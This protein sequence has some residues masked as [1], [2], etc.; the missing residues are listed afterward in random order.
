MLGGVPGTKS[1]LSLAMNPIGREV[2]QAIASSPYFSKLSMLDVRECGIEEEGALF[3]ALSPSMAALTSLDVWGNKLG[4]R[5]LSALISSPYLKRL[6]SLSLGSGVLRLLP[7]AFWAETIC[8]LDLRWSG[9]CDDDI[10]L[11]ANIGP[12]PV[13]ARLNLEGNPLTIEGVMALLQSPFLPSLRELYLGREPLTDEQW[14]ELLSDARFSQI[15]L[16]FGQISS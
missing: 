6:S 10:L 4:P 2:A 16:C 3:L 15:K 1:S 8:S 11:F 9:L 12:L 7:G 13:L 5:G 14:F